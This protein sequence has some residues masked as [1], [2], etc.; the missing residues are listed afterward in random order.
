MIG[1]D[2]QTIGA[3][4]EMVGRDVPMKPSV[5]EIL[6]GSVRTIVGLVRSSG[7]LVT[8]IVASVLLGGAFADA[9]G[10]FVRSVGD[11]VRN[12]VAFVLVFE[13]FDPNIVAV[14]PSFG[15]SGRPFPPLERLQSPH[16]QMVAPASSTSGRHVPF[17]RWI[18]SLPSA[19][20][21]RSKRT[22]MPGPRP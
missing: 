3:D 2:V 7:R 14:E 11:V 18:G 12:G 21:L 4:I 5:H 22:R 20:I 9:I 13:G 10:S 8:N 16:R 19:T 1:R 15:G 17:A 6:G